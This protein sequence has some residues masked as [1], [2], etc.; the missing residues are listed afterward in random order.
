VVDASGM[1]LA[2]RRDRRHDDGD[3]P[4]PCPSST[5]VIGSSASGLSTRSSPGTAAADS[6]RCR[7]RA[8]RRSAYS[9][10]W[11]ARRGLDSWHL[12]TPARRVLSAGAAAEP[13]ARLL[14]GGRPVAFVFRS[15]PGITDRLYRWVAGHQDRWARPQRIDAGCELKRRW[16]PRSRH[17]SLATASPGDHEIRHREENAAAA[18][19][20]PARTGGAPAVSHVSTLAEMLRRIPHGC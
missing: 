9:P 20:G 12:A 16:W 14:P 10:P 13:F 15:F 6:V 18:T 2:V 11:T 7:S 19:V 3:V 17:S 5:T 8:R 1:S 4:Q